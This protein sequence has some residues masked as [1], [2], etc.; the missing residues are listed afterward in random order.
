MHS[1]TV[2][3]VMTK[4]VITVRE[5]T[6]FK[7]LVRLMQTHDVSGLPVVD[8]NGCLTGIVTE[9]DLLELM[10]DPTGVKKRH[11]QFGQLLH[12][13]LDTGRTDTIDKSTA[14]VSAG[15]LMTIGLI[16]TTADTPVREAARHIVESGVK[17]LPV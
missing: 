4:R 1:L 10:G 2:G 15:T 3:E 9:A 16:T 17:R 11:T 7:E 13:L 14:H 6:P 8:A 12:R 5:E